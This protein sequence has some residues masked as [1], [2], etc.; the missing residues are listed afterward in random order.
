MEQGEVTG[1][2]GTK[3]D[4]ILLKDLVPIVARLTSKSKDTVSSVINEFLFQVVTEVAKGN[5]VTI[6]KFGSFSL[7]TQDMVY[8]KQVIL[9]RDGKYYKVKS[10]N[11][12]PFHVRQ[13]HIRFRKAEVL[14]SLLKEITNDGQVG[15]RREDGQPRRNG[16]EG[17]KR[18]PK[19]RTKTRSTRENSSLSELRQ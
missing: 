7:H 15:C 4:N 2:I 3:S 6:E 18:M 11:V 17:V 1:E 8:D 9:G 5:R 12:D 16:K 13:F 10:L 14:N 19:L